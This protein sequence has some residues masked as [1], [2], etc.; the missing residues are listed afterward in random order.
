MHIYI[1]AHC[2][3]LALYWCVGYYYVGEHTLLVY[4]SHVLHIQPREARYCGMQWRWAACWVCLY[5]SPGSERA[6]LNLDLGPSTWRDCRSI[7]T[8]TC[9]LYWL[10]QSWVTVLMVYSVYITARLPTRPVYKPA[11]LL[12]INCGPAC[13]RVGPLFDL[14]YAL[15]RFV[16]GPERFASGLTQ[17]QGRVIFTKISV[18]YTSISL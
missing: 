6:G 1:L 9:R 12:Y 3:L 15:V 17:Y 13:K 16:S 7:V 5:T 18:F 14:L 11:A 4:C 10:Y 2:V 8:F